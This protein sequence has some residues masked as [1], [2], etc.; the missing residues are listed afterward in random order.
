MYQIMLYT[1]NL[2]N[3]ICQLYREK[4]KE[5]KKNNKSYYFA[6]KDL[7]SQ[8]YGFPSSHVW[9]WELDQRRLSTEELTLSNSGVGEDTWES[10]G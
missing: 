1:L 4:A 5:K 10:L 8:S 3:V 9:M 6:D 7:Y 2:Q